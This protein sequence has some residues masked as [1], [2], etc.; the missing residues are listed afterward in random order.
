MKITIDVQVPRGTKR[1]ATFFGIPLAVIAGAAA[2][3]FAGVPNTFTSG[4]GLSSSKMNANFSALDGRLSALETAAGETATDGG[5][6][7][8]VFVPAGTVVAFAGVL[9]G[10]VTPPAGWLLC[11]GR[12]VSRTTYAALFGAI[13]TTAGAGDGATTFNL[14]DYRGYFLRGLDSEMTPSRDPDVAGRTALNSGGS[15]GASVGTLEADAFASHTHGVIDPGHVHDMTFARD[16]NTT[17]T[18]RYVSYPAPGQLNVNNNTLPATT[19]ISLQNSGG[20]ESRPKNVA[21]N[22][23]IKF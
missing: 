8:P 7:V 12:A 13:G 22:Y 23:I 11:D 3:A 14:P 20:A 1:I 5:T 10:A 6:T 21:V 15:T 9:G 18:N 2:I 4:E 16:Y 19:G 17:G